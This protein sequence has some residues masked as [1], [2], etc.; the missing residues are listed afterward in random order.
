MSW[1]KLDDRFT[2]H[3]KII[4]LGHVGLALQIRALCYAAR[5]QTDGFIPYAIAEIMSADLPDEPGAQRH[6]WPEFMVEGGV[7]E[8][9]EPSGGYRIH[10]F[11]A[12]QSTCCLRNEEW[13]LIPLLA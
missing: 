9:D 8:E 1:V 12:G 13:V 7:W 2:E 4:A 3:P 5:N 6:R 10:D 11:R